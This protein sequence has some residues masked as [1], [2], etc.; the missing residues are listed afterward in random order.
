[1]SQPVGLDQGQAL[2][3]HVEFHELCE[4]AGGHRAC[5][6]RLLAGSADLE[7]HYQYGCCAA[8]NGDYATALKE[9]FGVIEEDRNFLDGAAKDAMVSVFHLLGRHHP[10]VEDY[11]KRL[12]RLLY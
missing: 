6:E 10:V 11:P 12:Y 9:W 8:A 7:G 2:L 5:A 4:K 1:M 3:K